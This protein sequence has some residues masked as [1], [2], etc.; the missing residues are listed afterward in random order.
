MQLMM[1]SSVVVLVIFSL[2]LW[3]IFVSLFPKG[4]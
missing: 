1:T 3:L 4:E 2:S